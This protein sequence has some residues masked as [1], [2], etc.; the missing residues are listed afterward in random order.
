MLR[1]VMTEPELEVLPVSTVVLD[2]DSHWYHHTPGIWC[3]QRPGH[4]P[5]TSRQLAD[6]RP[7]LVLWDPTAPE[8]LLDLWG[9]AMAEIAPEKLMTDG[10]GLIDD[11]PGEGGVVFGRLIEVAVDAEMAALAHLDFINCWAKRVTS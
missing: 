1:I 6:G 2:T 10:L 5:C 7:L 9:G 11:L 8:V 3:W 4:V